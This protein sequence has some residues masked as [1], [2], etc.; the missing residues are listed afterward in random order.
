M[1]RGRSHP[2]GATVLC[3]GV[4]FSVYSRNCTSMELLL[5]D[6]AD[7]TH[8]SRVITLCP[9][10]NRTGNYWH[11]FVPGLNPGQI[12]AF[13]AHGPYEPEKG[14]LFDPGKILLDPYGKAVAVPDGYSRRAACGRG[15]NTPTAMKNVVADPRTY[16]WEGDSP[17]KRPFSRS[18]LYEMHVRGFT[19]NPNSG[20]SPEK[21]GTFAGLVEK[22]PY[23]KE[24]GITALELLPVF[25]FDWQD[26]PEGLVNY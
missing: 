14:L 13:R 7:S 1:R 12:Y 10:L 8:P 19:R 23:L 3:D 2:L 9:N 11:T 22:I 18:V 5:F 20:V 17:L 25:Q 15:E 16:D 6:S 21:R 4:N 24:L 26:C